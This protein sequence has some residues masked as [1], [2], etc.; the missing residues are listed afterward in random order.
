MKVLGIN[1]M[2]RN[3]KVAILLVIMTLSLGLISFN[4]FPFTMIILIT[5]INSIIHIKDM[6]SFSLDLV[7]KNSLNAFLKSFFTSF[8][9]WLTSGLLALVPFDEIIVIG[10]APPLDAPV[11]NI[12]AT[13]AAG[14]TNSPP[15]PPQGVL[16][17]AGGAI[18]GAPLNEVDDNVAPPLQGGVLDGLVGSPITGAAPALADSPPPAPQGIFIGAGAPITGAPLEEVSAGAAPASSPPPAPQVM[19]VGTGAPITGAPLYEVDPITGNPIGNPINPN[20]LH[21][22]NSQ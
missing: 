6:D 10:G 14:Q 15:A 2:K 16:V 13:P 1:T 7:I 19:L 4:L 9:Q 12:N 3:S 20:N 18:T 22:S 21:Q 5:F 8:V 17:G 11:A